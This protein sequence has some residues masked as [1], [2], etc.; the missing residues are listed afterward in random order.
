MAGCGFFGRDEWD[1]YCSVCKDLALAAKEDVV[2]PRE[3]GIPSAQQS[4]NYHEGLFEHYFDWYLK[5]TARSKRM[6]VL[7]HISHWSPLSVSPVVPG[8]RTNPTAHVST[9]VG[10][11]DE[12]ESLSEV[13]KELAGWASRGDFHHHLAV[14]RRGGYDSEHLLGTAAELMVGHKGDIRLSSIP[15]VVFPRQG[16]SIDG[17]ST[18]RGYHFVLIG[19]A[20]EMSLDEAMEVMQEEGVFAQNYAGILPP[21]VGIC[22]DM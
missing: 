16:E 17:F 8:V 20:H 22:K 7:D 4:E 1:G 14:F 13:L 5:K 10:L 2:A 12:D 11:Y 3:D 15:K 21:S 18:E 9:R 19:I 6:V